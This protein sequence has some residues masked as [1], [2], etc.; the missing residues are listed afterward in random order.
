[1]KQD[2]RRSRP[3][4]VTPR[5]SVIENPSRLLLASALGRCTDWRRIRGASSITVLSFLT[6]TEMVSRRGRRTSYR[7]ARTSPPPQVGPKHL[8]CAAVA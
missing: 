8:H 6:G 1:M 4:S 3:D 2:P 7:L 5:L